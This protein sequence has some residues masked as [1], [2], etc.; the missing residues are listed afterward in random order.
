MAL[1]AE[2]RTIFRDVLRNGAKLLVF[3]VGAGVLMSVAGTR[4]IAS[5]LWNVPSYDPLTLTGGAV[6]VTIAGLSACLFPAFRATRVDAMTAL[7]HE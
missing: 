7:R 2:R 3:G 6:V 4:I 1:G 5:Q